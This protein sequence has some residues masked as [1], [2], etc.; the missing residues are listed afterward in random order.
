MV[1]NK[2]PLPPSDKP[3]VPL[4]KPLQHTSEELDQLSQ[5][6]AEDIEKAQALWRESVPDKSQNLLNAKPVKSLKKKENP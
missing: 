2:T 4:G 1:K 6:T 3:R 5:I